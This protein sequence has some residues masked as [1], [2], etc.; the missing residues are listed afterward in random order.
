[1]INLRLAK[2]IMEQEDGMNHL[3]IQLLPADFSS[4]EKVEIFRA[5]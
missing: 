4:N 5:P 3:W 2:S 1:M